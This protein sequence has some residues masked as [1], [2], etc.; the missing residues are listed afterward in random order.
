MLSPTQH[1]LLRHAHVDSACACISTSNS[2]KRRQRESV[3][4]THS[5]KPGFLVWSSN[6]AHS[7]AV[8]RLA[9]IGSQSKP[10]SATRS[11][12]IESEF[13]AEIYGRIFRRKPPRYVDGTPVGF[14]AR[15]NQHAGQFSRIGFRFESPQKFSGRAPAIKRRKCAT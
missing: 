9:G 11:Q 12:S 6:Q 15:L 8:L 2:R 10:E 4:L 3:H 13:L 1:L 5:S 14:S 7:L